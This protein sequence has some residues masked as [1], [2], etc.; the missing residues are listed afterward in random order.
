LKFIERPELLQLFEEHQIVFGKNPASCS[1][2]FQPS[3]VGP[4]F[5]AVKSSLGH[6]HTQHWRDEQLDHYLKEIS[7]PLQFNDGL[8]QKFII[9]IQKAIFAIQNYATKKIITEGYD[10][11]GF[12]PFNFERILKKCIHQWEVN[13]IAGIIENKDALIACFLRD[14]RLTDEVMN[15][16]HIPNRNQELYGCESKDGFTLNRTRSALRNHL[17]IVKERLK[18]LDERKETREKAAAKKDFD[19]SIK[20]LPPEEQERLKKE[21]KASLARETRARNAAMRN[22][23]ELKR[24]NADA[25]NDEA[26]VPLEKKQAV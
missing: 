20:T 9:G 26:I 15:Q 2:I 13:E 22:N 18:W 23:K 10:D 24:T 21:R 16:Y 1:A 19:K 14:G 4:F 11:V 6:L 12:Y 8:K 3:D 17:Q 5:K 7:T 25:A